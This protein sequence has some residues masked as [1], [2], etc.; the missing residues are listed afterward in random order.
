M[1]LPCAST[2]ISPFLI[3]RVAF[4]CGAFQLIGRVHG[5]QADEDAKVERKSSRSRRS[6]KRFTASPSKRPTRP[7]ADTEAEAAGAEG[8]LFRV[9]NRRSPARYPRQV[10]AW[11]PQSRNMRLLPLRLCLRCLQSAHVRGPIFPCLPLYLH[12]KPPSAQMLGFIVSKPRPTSQ[13][14]HAPRSERQE[15]GLRGLRLMP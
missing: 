9:S 2:G 4:P 10:C 1:C 5:E 3:T 8:L 11:R 15:A 12:I 14:S 13:R 7:K 6:P